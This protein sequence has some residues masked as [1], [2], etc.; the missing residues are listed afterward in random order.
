MDRF[1]V[2][3]PNRH[4]QIPEPTIIAVAPTLTSPADYPVH[5]DGL[6]RRPA[7]YRESHLPSGITGHPHPPPTD[8]LYHVQRDHHRPISHFPVPPS[9]SPSP[10]EAVVTNEPRPRPARVA[11]SPHVRVTAQTPSSRTSDG[12]LRRKISDPMLCLHHCELDEEE[13]E[14]LRLATLRD[15]LE[16]R[17]STRHARIRDFVQKRKDMPLSRLTIS[18]K[19][20]EDSPLS[21][22]RD[23]IRAERDVWSNPIPPNEPLDQPREPPF[24]EMHLATC[25]GTSPGT[26]TTDPPWLQER[27]RGGT[28]WFGGLL[29]GSHG[30]RVHSAWYGNGRLGTG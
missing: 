9:P 4:P 30:P 20:K 24:H 18:N 11:S 6:Q 25:S 17:E 1:G 15:Y 12:L 10:A 23:L 3:F 2:S 7:L 13:R 26:A 8:H 29:G 5:L 27:R 14:K 21:K 28:S 16:R 22:V 19:A